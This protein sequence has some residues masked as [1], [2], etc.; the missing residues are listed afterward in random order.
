MKRSIL[1]PRHARWAWLPGILLI[2]AGCFG[3]TPTGTVSGTVKYK[4]QP[5][6]AG[7]VNFHNAAKGTASQAKL[8]GGNFT[9]PGELEVGTYK[10]YLQAPP[11]EQLPPDKMKD[12]KPPAFD[13]PPKYLDPSQTTE[14]V[15]VKAGANTFTIEFK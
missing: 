9:F 15:E 10:V 7:I 14:S 11:P 12:A 13:I 1:S 5:V 2:L 4:G 6:K 8:D 3:K